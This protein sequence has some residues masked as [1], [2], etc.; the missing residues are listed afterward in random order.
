MIK[1]PV[2]GKERN[3]SLF[4]VRVFFNFRMKKLLLVL[5]LLLTG[6]EKDNTLYIA[7]TTSLEN[8]GLLDYIIP[9]F[10]EE[11]G[12]KVNIIAVGT[13]AALQMGRNGDVDLLLVHAKAQEL[14]FVEE[15]YG[16]K[17]ADVMYN[18]FIFIGPAVIEEA[19]LDKAFQYL[20]DNELVF[21]SRGD[22]SGTHMKELSLWLEFGFDSSTFG[23]WYQETG[24]GMGST[25]MMANLEGNYTFTDRGTYLSMLDNIDLVI[26]YEN[27]FEL[28]NQYGVIKINPELHDVNENAADAFYN[29]I[30]SDDTQ[31]LIGNYNKYGETMFFPNAK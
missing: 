26:A 8:S 12:F 31:K 10:E 5:L 27:Y 15:G 19:P 30:L 20:L 29:W 1:P 16:E 9:V 6:C 11:T 22:N 23:S 24:Q 2:F 14:I 28:I 3:Y 17:R 4:L 7:T 21:Y 13:G 25:I 18:D